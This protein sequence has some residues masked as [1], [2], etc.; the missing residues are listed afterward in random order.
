MFWYIFKQQKSQSLFNFG[1]KI[2]IHISESFNEN[3]IFWQKSGCLKQCVS[4]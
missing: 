3:S 2:Q 4:V 1:A